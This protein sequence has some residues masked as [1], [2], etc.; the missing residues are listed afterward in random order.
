MPGNALASAAQPFVCAGTAA[1]FASACIHPID[2]TKVRL[3]VLPPPATAVSVATGILKKEGIGGLYAGLNAAILRQATY[4]TARIGLHDS[5]S[6]K[7]RQMNDGTNIPVYQKFASSFVSG[8]IAS[9]IGNP[10]DVTLVR[11]QADTAKPVAE[12][13]GYNGLGDAFVRIIREEGISALYRG[14]IPTLYRA[15]AMN[16]GQMTTY[17]EA[18]E[19]FEGMGL[20]GIKLYACS[21]V[22]SSFAATFL[23]LPFDMMKTRLQNMKPDN[24]GQ[25]PYKGV[26]DCARKILRQEGLFRFWRGYPAYFVRCCPHGLIILISKEYITSAYKGAFGL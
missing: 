2:I 25:L 9:S 18:K 17:D 12:R 20:V 16:V 19:R 13:Y 6:A 26:N 24:T 15:L 14:Y 8:A 21:S 5:F 11:M 22:V 10:F 23:S 7:L 4:G 1:C 3:Q